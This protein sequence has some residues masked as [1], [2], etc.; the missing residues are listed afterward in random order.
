MYKN[1][2]FRI[3]FTSII[4]LVWLITFLLFVYN[5]VFQNNALPVWYILL[6]V[7]TFS[8]LFMIG[9]IVLLLLTI[10]V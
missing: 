8:A 7:L 2:K 1:I 6:P 9:V 3:S 10:I 4:I 5:L